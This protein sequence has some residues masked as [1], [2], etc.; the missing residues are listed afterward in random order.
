MLICIIMI[1]IY[2]NNIKSTL[3]IQA[4]DDVV[5][6]RFPNGVT[7]FWYGRTDLPV[8]NYTNYETIPYVN[9]T[10]KINRPLDEGPGQVCIDA[11]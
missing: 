3:F 9:M 5:N 8:R 11:L 6:N 7:G 4:A 10:I 2:I 1:Q